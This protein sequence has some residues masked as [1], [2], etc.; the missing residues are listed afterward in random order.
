MEQIAL[1]TKI[2]PD[3]EDKKLC[4]MVRIVRCQWKNLVLISQFNLKLKTIT[5]NKILVKGGEKVKLSKKFIIIIATILVLIIGGGAVYA[6]NTPTAIAERQLKLGNK[7]LQE[8]KYQEAIL[9]FQKVIEIE[10]KNIPARLGLGKAYI[11]AKEYSKAEAVLKEVISL[12]KY[13]IPARQD[14]FNLYM[15]EKKLDDANSILQEITTIDPKADTK[16]LDSELESAKSINASKAS[17]DQ[18]VKQMN[19]KLYLEAVDSLQKVIN[20]DTERYSDAQTKIGDCKKTFVDVTLLKAKDAGSNKDYPIALDLLDQVLKVDPNN[21]DAS[22]LK[23]D[24]SNAQ[25]EEKKKALEVK[26]SN[27]TAKAPSKGSIVY[28]NKTCGFA[29]DIPKIWEGKYT[30]EETSYKG[31]KNVDTYRVTFS[32]KAKE[33]KEMIFNICTVRGTVNDLYD[34]VDRLSVFATHNDK[35]YISYDKN[36]YDCIYG[37]ESEMQEFGIIRKDVPRIFDTF[38]FI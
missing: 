6:T 14:L 38:R 36:G 23:D 34:E 16:Q 3:F 28:E 21:Q 18:G 5:F 24:Y 29:I 22:K 4:I 17:Y 30:V 10:P 26:G 15:K 37:N 12:D 20:E 7:Y 13:N 27:D 1:P 8:G 33:G 9:A 32:Y 31:Y 11:A 25:Q 19:D 35:L 2:S